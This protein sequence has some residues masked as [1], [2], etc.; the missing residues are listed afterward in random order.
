MTLATLW[1]SQKERAYLSELG[2]RGCRVISAP[3]TRA[4]AAWN[5]LRTLPRPIPLQ[6]VYS[7]QPQLLQAVQAAIRQ[8]ESRFDLVHI[9]HLRGARYGTHLESTLR[10]PRNGSYSL[11]YSAIPMV[12]DSV[13]CISHLFEQSS[14]SSRSLFGRLVT[15]FEL[16]RT[17]WYEA[18]LVGRFDRV[19]ITSEQDRLAFCDLLQDIAPSSD[20]HITGMDKISLLAN[21]VDLDYFKPQRITRTPQTLILSG[22]MSYHA[23]ATAALYL[24][25]EVMPLVWDRVP[26]ARVQ[27]V[28]QNPPRQIVELARRHPDRVYV[29][30][31][32]ADLRPY[33][34]QATLAVAPII[35]GAGIQNK[36]L[37]AMAMATPVVAT[38]KAVSAISVH[39][40]EQV[41]IGDDP[42]SFSKQVIRL[43]RNPAQ[44]ERLGQNGRTFVEMNHDWHKIAARLEAIYQ[45]V[46]ARRQCRA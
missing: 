35:Y 2:A 16:P 22:K 25:N 40:G 29:T 1:S 37:E 15:R 30:G 36:V 9:E 23:N 28:G 18:W 26:S 43:L 17:R 13:D 27:I 4:R 14:R 20:G 38:S 21:G 8:S 34:A 19:L 32:V 33:L 11:S 3:L 7:W 24:V 46:I 39:D 42:E 5:C 31:T 10:A 41:L 6:S 45:E 12:W 44:G